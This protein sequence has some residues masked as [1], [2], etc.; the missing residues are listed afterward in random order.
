MSNSSENEMSNYT[1][2]DYT[3]IEEE[4]Y[5][6]H[7]IVT[8]I[9]SVLSVAGNAFLLGMLLRQRWHITHGDFWKQV[10]HLAAINLV[11]GSLMAPSSLTVEAW[12]LSQILC[13]LIITATKVLNSVNAFS[14]ASLNVDRLFFTY[15]PSYHT[16]YTKP[17]QTA[18]KIV[19]PW[20]VVLGFVLPYLEFLYLHSTVHQNGHEKMCFIIFGE[21]EAFIFL[22]FAYFLPILG[23]FLA[24]I[25]Q[26]I[27]LVTRQLDKHVCNTAITMCILDGVYILMTLPMFALLAF[28]P[29]HLYMHYWMLCLA[30]QI[31]Q[32]SFT[33]VMP[34]VWLFH[35]DYRVGYHRTL[36]CRTREQDP[37]SYQDNM[38]QLLQ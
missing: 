15:R 10:A 28:L 7:L 30:A 17:W 32:I 35:D 3:A 31:V 13:R 37:H 18:L 1:Y 25:G 24:F 9:V 21:T 26:I 27:M 20:I 8:S 4:D 22:V 14:L 2:Y 6:W 33:L 12:H 19:V 23:I 11:W 29:S 5:S 36:L 34:I 16:G 38:M